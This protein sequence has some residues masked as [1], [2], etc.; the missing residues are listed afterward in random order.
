MIGLLPVSWT[1]QHMKILPSLILTIAFAGCAAPPSSQPDPN[2]FN[3]AWEEQT[4]TC[5]RSIITE[6]RLDPLRPK[7]NFGRPLTLE[8]QSQKE[9]VAESEKPALLAYDELVNRCAQDS[10][11]VLAR[12]NAHPA[13]TRVLRDDARSFSALL[14][15]LY[16]GGI[17]YG[18]FAQKRAQHRSQ[19]AGQWE[20]AAATD[21]A[22]REAAARA[23]AYA[24]A[25][26]RAASDANDRALLEAGA[27]LLNSAPPIP[28]APVY[29]NCTR[30]GNN[31]NCVSR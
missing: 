18:Q 26:A 7:I 21:R 6:S 27:R 29:T 3:R 11:S 28:V 30:N 24:A 31:V 22:D 9:F 23:N 4:A 8:E 16:Q 5:K 12:F 14:L 1:V 17:S 10:A 15:E 25:E 2:A 19:M 13:Y 20:Q